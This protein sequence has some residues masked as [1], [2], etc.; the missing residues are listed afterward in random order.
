[1]RYEIELIPLR[2]AVPAWQVLDEATKQEILAAKL[3]LAVGRL[4]EKHRPNDGAGVRKYRTIMRPPMFPDFTAKDWISLKK[5]PRPPRT[6]YA[7]YSDGHTYCDRQ[8]L[9]PIYRYYAEEIPSIVMAY[10]AK[11]RPAFYCIRVEAFSNFKGPLFACMAATEPGDGHIVLGVWQPTGRPRVTISHFR[12]SV[13][14]AL[15]IA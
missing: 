2:M 6:L 8:N 1:M 14:K 10:I 12:H 9:V 15:S 5:G 11:A 13:R 3:G 7:F 4:G